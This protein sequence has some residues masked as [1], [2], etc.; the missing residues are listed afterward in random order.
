[1]WSEIFHERSDPPSFLYEIYCIALRCYFCLSDSIWARAL[2]LF[3]SWFFFAFTFGIRTSFFHEGYEIIGRSALALGFVVGF[4]I[5]DDLWFGLAVGILW[6]VGSGVELCSFLNRKGSACACVCKE[7]R[8][9]RSED[10]S[11]SSQAS[12]MAWEVVGVAI[13][14]RALHPM[15]WV[16]HVIRRKIRTRRH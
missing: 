3:V 5:W 10:D 15:G 11:Q 1:M 16:E 6:T 13:Y 8:D 7:R 14:H 4:P 12:V 9:E 2:V